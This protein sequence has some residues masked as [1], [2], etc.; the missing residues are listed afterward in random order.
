MRSTTRGS[1]IKET[2]RMR[3]PHEQSRG[4]TSKIFLT[5]RAHVLRASLEKSELSCPA[6]ASAAVAALPA[7]A[8]EIAALA[9]LE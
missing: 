9:R 4:S 2:M 1:V 7:S 6:R 8:D 5:R 3:V